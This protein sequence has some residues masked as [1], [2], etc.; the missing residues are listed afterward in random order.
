[1]TNCPPKLRGDLSKWLIEINTGVYVGQVNA[2]VRNALW[3]R[4]CDNIS[5]GQATMVFTTNT[6]QHMD[7]Y[8][9][10]TSWKPVDFDG[11]KLMKHPDNH[12]IDTLPPGFSNDSKRLLNKRRRRRNTVDS[13]IVLDLETTGL[14]PEKDSIIEIGAIEVRDS[15]ICKIYEKLLICNCAI[16]KTVFDLTGIN[17]ELLKKEGTDPK[18]ALKGLFEFIA[19]RRVLIY[20][21]S[22][23]ISF[24]KKLSEQLD[25][26][27]PDFVIEDVLLKVKNKLKGLNNY[28]LQTVA[29]YLNVN[30]TQAHRAINDCKLL[31]EVYSKLNRI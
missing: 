17:D 19:D 23:D 31:N 16:P 22:F 15:E 28:K 30:L 10:N 29:E 24:M 14:N 2:K 4:V 9:H 3:K 11:I 13:Y 6:E 12:Q 20:N 26:D 21:V 8:V 27:Y 1:M 18:E 25:L 7:F 5:N